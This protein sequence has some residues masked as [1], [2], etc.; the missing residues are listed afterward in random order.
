MR[1]LRTLTVAAF[2]LVVGIVCSV[3]L[4]RHQQD[5]QPQ[6]HSQDAMTEAWMAYMKVGPEHEML[7]KHFEGTWDTDIKWLMGGEQL[8]KG[9]SEMKMVLGGRFLQ[10]HF[11]G[12]MHG[13]P[14]QGMGMTGYDNARKKYIGTWM[15]SMGTGVLVSEGDYDPATKTYTFSGEMTTPDGAAL[16]VREVIK[17]HDDNK[18]TFEM[19]MPGPD[20]NEGLAMVI[21]YT[22]K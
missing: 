19:Y 12:V 22:R 7:K 1:A 18:H 11:D 17:V 4:S 14:M 8:S 20:G 9:T 10:Q 16:T 6:D 15:D 2:V 5:M 3:A 21:T 13:A